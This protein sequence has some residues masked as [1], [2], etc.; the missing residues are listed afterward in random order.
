TNPELADPVPVGEPIL[1]VPQPA[2]NHNGGT[3]EFSPIDGFLYI[4][5]GDGGGG[6][7]TYKTGQSLD[8]L[9][10]KVL[11][12]DVNSTP[13]AIPAGNF[14]AGR[15]E[16]YINGLRNPF[17][18]G[19]DVCTG[20]LYIG[21]VGQG[22]REEIDIAPPGKSG[23]NYGWSIMEGS[24]CATASGCNVSCGQET[25]D[26]PAYEYAHEK[27]R[28]S[29]T[30]GRVY[31]GKAIPWLRGAYLFGDFCTGEVWS[32]RPTMGGTPEVVDLTKDLDGPLGQGLV[33]FGEDEQGELYIVHA[34]GDVE[35]IEPEN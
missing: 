17:R 27:Q 32:L 33:A 9:L 31:R 18:M 24:I 4:G 14:T 15:P 20:E 29:V 19:F 25:F 8:T 26:L 6:C 28:C 34:S 21:D 35:R 2:A 1:T 11:R 22:K 30:G 16:I 5:L 23:L 3:I 7:D 10:G 13:Y 12:I